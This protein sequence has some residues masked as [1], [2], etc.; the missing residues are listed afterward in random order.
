[1]ELGGKS[2]VIIFDDAD[3]EQAIAGAAE[4]ILLNCG[5]MCFAGSRLLAHEK[6][7]DDIVQGVADIARN[8]RIGPGMEPDTELGPLISARQRKRVCEYIES[9]TQEGAE[10][11]LGG[12]P[13]GDR[14]YFM[15]PTIITDTLPHMRVVREEIFGPVLVTTSFTETAEIMDVA[16]VAND[17]DYGLVATI[18]TR[19]LSRAHSLAAEI[20]AGMVWVNT[21]LAFDETLP[22]GGFK[23]SGWGRESS[24]M[25]IDEYT[26]SKSVIIAL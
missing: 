23:Q 21:P 1:M 24:R 15:E 20:K 10:V 4:M 16:R 12:K 26:E 17:T 2:P 14:G 22:F 19:D 18:W 6:V 3:I 11:L 9:G 25:C 5:Q 13:Y 7:Y 8:T